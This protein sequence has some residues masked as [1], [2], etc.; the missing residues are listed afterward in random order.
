MSRRRDPAASV[1][2]AADIGGTFTD[3]AMTLPNGAIATEKLLSTPDGYARA[4]VEGARRLLARN[5]LAPGDVTEILHG[6]TVATNAILEL[7]G[8]RTALITTEGFRDVLELRRIRTPRLYDPTWQKPQPLVPRH[9]RL[10]VRERI[11]HDGGNVTPLD[12]QS[13]DSV[14]AAVE[15]ACVD[16]VAVCFI[17]AFA[18]PSHELA[19]IGRAH[20]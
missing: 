9:L 12:S 16:A 2:L 4:V 14:M 20:V 13:V 15:A 7:K 19:E 8:A 10:E 18:N 11:A 3:L 1:R 17:N 5:G 6:C